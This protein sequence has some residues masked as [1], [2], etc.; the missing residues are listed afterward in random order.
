MYSERIVVWVGG[1]VDRVVNGANHSEDLGVGE[2][3]AG[4]MLGV[5]VGDHLE[6]LDG[7]VV[8]IALHLRLP[9]VASGL[10]RDLDE[11]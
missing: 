7:A 11:R 5:E 9:V 10:R 2:D 6:E 4:L 3:V 1:R 8:L